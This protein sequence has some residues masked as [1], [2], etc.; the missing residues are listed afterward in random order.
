MRFLERGEEKVLVEYCKKF[1]SV[2]TLWGFLSILQSVLYNR[3]IGT[4]GQEIVTLRMYRYLGYMA[5]SE[6]FK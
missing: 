5:Y 2:I 4:K 6:D 3:M 1:H